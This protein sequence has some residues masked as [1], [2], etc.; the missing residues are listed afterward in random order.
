M[1]VSAKEA[2]AEATEYLSGGFLSPEVT[3]GLE[4]QSRNLSGDCSSYYFEYHCSD[5]L[6]CDFLCSLTYKN[7]LPLLR[8]L[9]GQPVHFKEYL[10]QVLFRFLENW[11]N[12]KTG[13]SVMIPHIWLA[14][15]F[16][17]KQGRYGPPNIHFCIDRNFLNRTRF[18]DYRN[19]LPVEQLQSTVSTVAEN[20]FSGT[21]TMKIPSLRKCFRA[22][23]AGGEVLHLSFMHNRMPPVFKLNTTIPAGSILPVLKEAGWSGDGARV[24]KIC[25]EFAPREKRIK[26]NLCFSRKISRKL[27]I[28]L[29]YNMPLKSNTGRTRMLASLL[30]SGLI[31]P[32]QHSVFKKWS[33]SSSINSGKNGMRVELRR[34]LDVKL[35]I[36]K[37][38]GVACK[39]YLGFAPLPAIK[40]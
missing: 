26:C 37:T 15:D 32:S 31:T 4:G 13:L 3:G 25:S 38:D 28:E 22:L 40:W 29:E 27:E 11:N 17:R 21:D 12:R 14:F 20:C 10:W 36:G 9:S 24:K 30:D 19:Y 23:D 16:N 5:P 2:I 18:P 7:S 34:W 1:R 6:Q 8:R 35:C 33:G 39:A